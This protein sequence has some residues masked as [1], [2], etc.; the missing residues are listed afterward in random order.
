MHRLSRTIAALL[1]C[2]AALLAQDRLTF[3]VASVNENPLGTAQRLSTRDLRQPDR[4]STVNY[5]IKNRNYA[6]RTSQSRSFLG[7]VPAGAKTSSGLVFEIV[8]VKPTMPSAA[9]RVGTGRVEL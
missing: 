5:P 6:H 8:S 7:Q 2:G 4:F 9:V 3:E 1:V